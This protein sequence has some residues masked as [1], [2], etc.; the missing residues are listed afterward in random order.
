MKLLPGSTNHTHRP[1]YVAQA[2]AGGRDGAR[3]RFAGN[4]AQRSGV[5]QC[6]HTGT[7]QAR[8]TALENENPDQLFAL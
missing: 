4:A 2:W 7:G 1:G 3:E 6:Q 5:P 8:A